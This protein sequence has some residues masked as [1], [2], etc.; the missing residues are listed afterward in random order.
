MNNGD[1]SIWRYRHY[2]QDGSVAAE[3]TIAIMVFKDFHRY[4]NIWNDITAVAT[5]VA[6]V[7]FGAVVI[8]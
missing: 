8:I 7:V 1:G 5:V 3:T 2:K 4:Y 6:M